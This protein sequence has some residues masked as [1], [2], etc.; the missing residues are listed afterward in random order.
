MADPVRFG[1]VNVRGT[2]E[3]LPLRVRVVLVR[4]R[5]Y[6]HRP[7]HRGSRRTAPDLALRGHEG[8]GELLCH[9]YHHLHDMSMVALRFFTVYGPR[10]RPDLAIHKFAQLLRDGE[11]I[12]M[13]GDGSTERDDTHIEDIVTGVL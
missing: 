10:Q 12:P 2:Y 11:L 8:G 6:A 4:L 7:V 1:T 9:T 13:Y 3:L 5:Q